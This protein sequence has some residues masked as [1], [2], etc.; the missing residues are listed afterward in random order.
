M[1]FDVFPTPWVISIFMVDGSNL[2]I[3]AND[4]GKVQLSAPESK[5]AK[6][7]TELPDDVTHTSAGTNGRCTV[8][9]VG[10]GSDAGCGKAV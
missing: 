6:H 5:T 8:A 4:R 1:G 3:F 10:N 9:P 2:R 7:L